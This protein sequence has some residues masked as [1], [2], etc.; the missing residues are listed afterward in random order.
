M[1]IKFRI[2]SHIGK[3]IYPEIKKTFYKSYVVIRTFRS[4]I[5]YFNV[6]K[7]IYIYLVKHNK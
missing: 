6:F 1:Q 3:C 4:D 7:S 2:I 5:I